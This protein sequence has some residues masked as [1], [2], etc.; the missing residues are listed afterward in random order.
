MQY[1]KH[2][3]SIKLKNENKKLEKETNI[4]ENNGLPVSNILEK[5]IRTK[6]KNIN[7]F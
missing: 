1:T 3:I 4:V 2:V 5:M 7:F 6:S